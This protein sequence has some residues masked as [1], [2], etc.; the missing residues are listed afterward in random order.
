[1]TQDDLL[2]T[3]CDREAIRT[4]ITRFGRYL[5]ERRWEEHADLYSEDGVLELPFGSWTGRASILARVKRDLAD[6]VATQHVSANHDVEVDGDYRV[7]PHHVHRDPRHGRG[8]N[9]L[10]AGRWRLRDGFSAVRRGP[11]QIARVAISP[12]WRSATGASFPAP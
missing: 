11:W 12:V 2:I 8:R 6:Y 7:C 1:M 5:D 9:S 3:L 10:L 4:Q